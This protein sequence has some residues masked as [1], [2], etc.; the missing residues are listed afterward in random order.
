[1]QIKTIDLENSDSV[2]AQLL[3]SFQKTGF[4]IIKNHV[5]STWAIEQA[6]ADWKQFFASE[7]KFGLLFDKNTHSGYFPFKSENAKDYSYKDL[8]EFF[9]IFNHKQIPSSI[10]NSTGVLMDQLQD[11]GLELLEQL[12]RVMPEEMKV[13]V[14]APLPS[15]AYNSPSTLMR[16]LHYPPIE[17]AGQSVRSAAHE[18]INMITLLPVATTPGLQVKDVEGNWHEVGGDPNQIIV[19][20]GDMLQRMTNG[21]LKSTTHRVINPV[22]DAAKLSRY[23]IALFMHAHPE[24]SVAPGVTAQDYLNERLRELGLK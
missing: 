13:N 1:M 18:D 23:S 15:L 4:A 11:L 2:G 9:H 24:A 7:E 8:K 22:G 20:V 5:V 19:N 17:E 21:A 3:E 14:E 12:D 6:Y 16:V 10:G